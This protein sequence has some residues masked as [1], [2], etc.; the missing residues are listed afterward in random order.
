MQTKTNDEMKLW[1]SKGI[2]C[3]GLSIGYLEQSEIIF[4]LCLP[5]KF[6]YE[7]LSISIY[8][9]LRI[10]EAEP[11]LSLSQRYYQVMINPYLFIC[12]MMQKN[13]H[14]QS[15]IWRELYFSAKQTQNPILYPHHHR[16]GV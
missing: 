16:I 11:E 10:D 12:E 4:V 14:T 9:I 5:I 8:L 1:A 3:I 15:K 7:L 13:G 6:V 2:S